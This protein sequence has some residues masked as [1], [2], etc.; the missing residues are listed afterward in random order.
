MSNR[1]VF[2]QELTRQLREFADY[3]PQSKFALNLI[4]YQGEQ[5]RQLFENTRIAAVAYSYSQGKIWWDADG[6]LLPSSSGAVVTYD[7]GIPATNTGTI[8][9]V[10]SPGGIVV[11]SPWSLRTTDIITQVNTIKKLAAQRG[12]GYAPK[13]ALYGQNIPGYISQNDMVRSLFPFD[14]NQRH[15]LTKEGKIPQGFLGLEWVPVQTSFWTDSSGNNNEIFRQDYITFMPEIT[16]DTYALYQGTRL[17]PKSFAIAGSGADVLKNMDE[18]T[19]MGRFAYPD[20]FSGFTQIVDE[21]FDT[22]APQIRT[23]NAVFIMNTC[24]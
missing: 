22:F 20:P 8:T 14:E 17:V 18:V 9:D 2:D 3:K 24:P 15:A 19:G 1:M 21:G 5:F 11:S 13:Y 12:G 10:N 16:K 4:A 23:P 7:Q 6:F